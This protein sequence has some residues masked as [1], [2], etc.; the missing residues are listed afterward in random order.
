MRPLSKI[1][2]QISNWLCSHSLEDDTVL[3]SDIN[4]NLCMKYISIQ[5]VIFI[6]PNKLLSMLQAS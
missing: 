6:M 5:Y 1:Q 2:S 3:F 4:F